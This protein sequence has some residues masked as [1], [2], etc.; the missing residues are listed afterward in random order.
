MPVRLSAIDPRDAR[1]HYVLGLV[2]AALD[3]PREAFQPYRI[4]VAL[5]PSF[6]RAHHALG[7]L[8]LKTGHSDL[9]EP[10]LQLAAR[11][12]PANWR[13]AASLARVTP[14]ALRYPALRAAL[15]LGLHERP[16][17]LGLRI[18]STVRIRLPS[19]PDLGESPRVDPR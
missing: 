12:E 3:R 14:G 17:S 1:A 18:H 19:S 15:R 8:L 9:A 11:L 16:R 4:A 6:A 2:A 10:E 13:F 5:D 7:L